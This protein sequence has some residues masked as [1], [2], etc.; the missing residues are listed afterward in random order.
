MDILCMVLIFNSDLEEIQEVVKN[1]IWKCE[2]K[3]FK[4]KGDL[5][6]DFFEYVYMF[7]NRYY[8]KRLVIYFNKI[9]VQKIYL[10]KNL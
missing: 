10:K 5:Y 7:L 2:L 9:N 4:I 8:V 6:M 1:V 3:I